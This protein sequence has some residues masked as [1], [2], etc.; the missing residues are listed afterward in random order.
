MADGFEDGGIEPIS[1]APTDTATPATP[2]VASPTD[3]I[4]AKLTEFGASEEII[5]A[6][7]ALGVDTVDD[8]SSLTETD[9]VGVG[10]PVVKAR[11]LLAAVKPAP[12]VDAGF[13][14][15]NADLLP[16]TPDDESWLKALKIGGVL[17]VDSS[18]VIAAIRAALAKRVG[19]YDVPKRLVA[20]MEQFADE[21]EEQVDPTYFAL[22]KQITRRNYSEIFGAI[23]GL[24]GTFVTDERKKLLLTRLD[25]LL[26]PA[27]A[28]FNGQLRAWREN[29]KEGFDPTLL[30]LGAISGQNGAV[31][32]G[33]MTP[34]DSSSV[35]A[36]ADAVK[37]AI[38]KVF[39]GT[40]VQIASALA[41]EASEIKKSLE[42]PRLPSLVGA[43]NRDL[44]IKKLGVG[45]P[46]TYPRLETNL[47]RYV[48]G[49]LDLEN[50]AAGNEELAY[51]SALFSLGNALDL[52]QLSLAGFDNRRLG[53]AAIGAYGRDQL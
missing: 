43:A 45:V 11:K 39:A 24:D 22:R 53:S 20:A 51:L 35:R 48:L 9:L 23:D 40:G 3:P 18:T 6:V 33:T 10:L 2:V 37:D 13:V 30:I 15:I 7:K 41:Y 12:T 34:P 31:P 16:V 8:L 44:L 28:E 26:W 1:T 32:P 42:D 21:S 50:Q 14:G 19:L 38:N 36:S 5:T 52:G 47:T 49:I 46:A 17:K 4:A 29:W 27:I 25:Q